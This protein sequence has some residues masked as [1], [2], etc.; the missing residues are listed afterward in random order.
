M[1][2]PLQMNTGR[3]RPRVHWCPTG[4]FSFLPLHAARS[5]EN[6]EQ[7]CFRY[8]VSSYTPTLAALL[9]ARQSPSPLPVAELKALLVS[10]PASPNR[11]YLDCV[12]DEVNAVSGVLSSKI[13][14]LVTQGIK[15]HDGVSVDFLTGALPDAVIVHLACHGQQ[16]LEQPLNSGFCLRDGILTI[17]ELMR[18][19]LPNAMLAF[20]SACETAK[21][22]PKHADQAVHLAAAMLF[23][24][25]RSIVGTMW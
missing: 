14:A 20:L 5:A 8:M 18:L 1:L 24:G 23:V 15:G 12:I 4:S 2:F 25:F 17:S 21:G 22:D 11:E 7:G 13:S 19:E 16:D 9:K 6:A 10:E 3:G